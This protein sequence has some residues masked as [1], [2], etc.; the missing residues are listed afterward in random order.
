MGSQES[1]E[2]ILLYLLSGFAGLLYEITWSR[3]LALQLGHTSGAISTVLAAFMG[4]LAAGAFFGGRAASRLTPAQALR[5]YAY[6]ELLV[7]ACAIA[8]PLVLRAASPVLAGLYGDGP[9][10]IFAVA[11]VAFCLALVSIPAAL[12]GATYPI[13]IRGCQALPRGGRAERVLYASNAAG[14]ALGAVATGFVLLPALGAAKT[15]WIG[16]LV[17]VIAAAGAI[18][19]ARHATIPESTARE[20]ALSAIAPKARRWTAYRNRH[21]NSPTFPP[22][23]SLPRLLS[24]HQGSSRSSAR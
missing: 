16:V 8:L 24:S 5:A 14:A 4:G 17:N 15:I 13:A 2:L 22:A 1:E 10:A 19:L 23:P 7:A 18:Y 9:S 3:L 12:M 11:R 21:E 20:A 6:L